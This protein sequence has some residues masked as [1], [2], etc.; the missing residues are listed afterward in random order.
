[1]TMILTE[2]PAS[3]DGSPVAGAAGRPR[4]RATGSWPST[5]RP[6]PGSPTRPGA[7]G[8][9]LV[10]LREHAGQQVV[11]TVE[12]AGGAVEEIPVTLRDAEAAVTQGALGV[13][14]PTLAVGETVQRTILESIQVGLQRTIEACG[15]I[16]VAVRD[17]FADIANP[18]VSGPLGILGAVGTVRRA[19][20]GLLRLPRGPAVGQPGRRQR[21]AAAARWTV[22]AWRSRSSRPSR[23]SASASAPSGLTYCARLRAP[24][25]LPRVH[26]DLRHRAARGDALTRALPDGLEVEGLPHLPGRR[27]T[28]T[29][30]VG[31]RA[32]RQ[33]PPGRRPVDDQHRHRRRRR[34]RAP[35]RG[36][37]P[38]R[39]RS[40]CA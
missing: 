27:Q 19:A 2:L 22:A 18:Q 11:L 25:G 16:L 8:T 33:P 17:L 20:A 26:H 12:R 32:C 37:G 23:A 35:G 21:A 39:A 4:R 5:A 38:R 13:K 14:S 31:G 30:D 7:P 3:A 6:S 10:Y 9:P 34:D 36:P 40:S 15:L 29:V 24:D 1:M 28:P